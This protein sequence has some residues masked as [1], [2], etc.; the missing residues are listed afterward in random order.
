MH[1]TL[2]R[3]HDSIALLFVASCGFDGRHR[4]IE[5]AAFVTVVDDMLTEMRWVN[6]LT[7]HNEIR[8]A[9]GLPVVD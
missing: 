2:D 3:H 4:E 5:V 7:V 1:Q 6:D 8:A 9:A